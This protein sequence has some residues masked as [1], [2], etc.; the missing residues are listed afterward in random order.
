MSTATRPNLR[1]YVA[2]CMTCNHWQADVRPGAISDLGGWLP[3]ITAIGEAHAE[4]IQSECPNAGG[5]VNFNG[6]WA[7]PPKM[8]SGNPA[9]GTMAL[10]PLP[11]WWVS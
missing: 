6:Q 7:E 5:R 3:A 4:H 2:V 1:K 11:R 9:T 10:H 8:A